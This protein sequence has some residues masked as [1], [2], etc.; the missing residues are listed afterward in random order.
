MRTSHT[1][2]VNPTVSSIG[3]EPIFDTFETLT[4]CQWYNV[5][6]D[7]EAND[8]DGMKM[9]HESV[10][11]IKHGGKN[12][13]LARISREWR[14]NEHRMYIQSF[15]RRVL[16]TNTTNRERKRERLVK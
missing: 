4:A 2:M 8:E 14:E 3:K 15:F 6:E 7:N 11:W 9:D 12:I 5:Q 13:L 1:D 10:E 16:R